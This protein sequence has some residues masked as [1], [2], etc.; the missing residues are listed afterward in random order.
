MAKWTE[1]LRSFIELAGPQPQSAYA[2]LT[3]G[4]VGKWLYHLRCSPC[5]EHL[6]KEMDT[7]LSDELLQALFGCGVPETQ[8]ARALMELPARCGGISLPILS[9][10]APIEHSASMHVTQP[11]VDMIIPPLNPTLPIGSSS[12]SLVLA[13]STSYPAD[14]VVQPI[15]DVIVG[16]GG[17]APTF[18]D[19]NVC[20]LPERF[21]KMSLSSKIREGLVLSCI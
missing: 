10:M 18:G 11:L 6:L 1:E 15:S 13:P 19:T 21:E 3:K 4:L 5:P 8:G 20:V 9:R 16:V 7:L 2:V 14:G 17:I 12:Q